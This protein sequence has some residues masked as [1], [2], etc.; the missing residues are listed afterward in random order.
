MLVDWLNVIHVTQYNEMQISLFYYV[1]L[2]TGSYPRLE[3]KGKGA[4]EIDNIMFVVQL[5]IIND[6][7]VTFPPAPVDAETLWGV[8]ELPPVHIYEAR[9]LLPRILLLGNS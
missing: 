6:E 2:T 7:H 3:P 1:A 8:A 4:G 9:S 5:P